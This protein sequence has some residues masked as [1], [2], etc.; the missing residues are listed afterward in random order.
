MNLELTSPTAPNSFS[1]KLA[2][3]VALLRRHQKLAV[4]MSPGGYY[5]AFSGGKDSQALYHVAKLA[6]VRFEP[7]YAVTT[8][9]P[10]ELVK[11]IRT[12]YPDVIFD[13]PHEPFVSLCLRKRMLPTM[14]IRFC[15]A[16]L[17]ETKGAGSVTLTGVRR[18]ESARRA[19][20][21]EVEVAGHKFSGSSSQFDQF[22]RSKRVEP[23]RCVDGRDKVI[24]NPIIDWTARDVWHFLNGV[25]GVEHCCLYDEGWQRIGCMFCPMASQK[26]IERAERRYPKYR[27][28]FIR[29]IDG[30]M[31]LGYYNDY[32]ELTAEDIFS[33]W[34]SNSNIKRFI[35]DKNAPQLF[36]SQQAGTTQ[37]ST[38]NYPLSTINSQLSTHNS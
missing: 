24:V 4:E 9:D 11:F 15:C 6:G 26:N 30:L 20:R 21:N 28:K 14:K 36:T 18:E 34:K 1:D 13:H 27:A 33:L 25:V 22:T 37:L 5:L 8:L 10:P 12:H 32:P 29:L 35:A 7:H 3:S 23:L 2:N 38:I 31:Q 17:K 19:R 16:L